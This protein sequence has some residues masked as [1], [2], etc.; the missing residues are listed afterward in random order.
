[1]SFSSVVGY[2]TGAR[3]VLQKEPA[4]AFRTEENALK[5]DNLNDGLG[6]MRE[7]FYPTERRDF[8]M[9]ACHSLDWHRPLKISAL[10]DTSRVM[11]TRAKVL[12]CI[13]DPLRKHH[14]HLC[15]FM[16]RLSSQLTPLKACTITTSRQVMP[17]DLRII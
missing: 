7:H 8:V 5:H 14:S 1:M 3:T 13:Q 2:S 10:P 12:S 6:I 4:D 15:A 16:W 9:T 17:P 11:K